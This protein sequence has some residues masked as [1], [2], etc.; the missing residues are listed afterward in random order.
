MK[1]LKRKD[2]AEEVLT[3]E[4]QQHLDMEK[5]AE[6]DKPVLQLSLEKQ[7]KLIN[8]VKQNLGL[9]GNFIVTAMN[10]RQ[11]SITFSNSAFEVTVKVRDID[12]LN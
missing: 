6:N 8:V 12:L 7:E 1:A 2:V 10:D 3:K 9:E 4:E 5:V 11:C